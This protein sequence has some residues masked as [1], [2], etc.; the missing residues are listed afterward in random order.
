MA[1]QTEQVILLQALS[2]TNN[3]HVGATC[4]LCLT[5]GGLTVDGLEIPSKRPRCRE[6]LVS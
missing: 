6:S 1:A 2:N 4:A 3:L 5:K